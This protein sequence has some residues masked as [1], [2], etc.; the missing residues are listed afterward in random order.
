LE[1]P[2]LGLAQHDTET[3]S[4]GWRVPALLA[5]RASGAG[6]AYTGQ[7][8]AL[9]A[10]DI[11]KLTSGLASRRRGCSPCSRYFGRCCIKTGWDQQYPENRWTRCRRCHW[12][13]RWRPRIESAWVYRC[14]RQ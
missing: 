5:R 12:R 13:T 9:N 4:T 2:R 1:D 3:T 6:G 10:S 7:A 14:W 8:N 11:S